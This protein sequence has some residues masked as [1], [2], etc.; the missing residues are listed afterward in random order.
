[1]CLSISAASGHSE[2]GDLLSS[3]QI[4]GF[5][6]LNPNPH[7]HHSRNIRLWI[8]VVQSPG[9]VSASSVSIAV[10]W[11]TCAVRILTNILSLYGQIAHT[12]RTIEHLVADL[13]SAGQ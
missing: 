3:E 7:F 6:Y 4:T 1:M 12:H 11:G 13:R 10:T 5:I 8:Y 9:S 2:L